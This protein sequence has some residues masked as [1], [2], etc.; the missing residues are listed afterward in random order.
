M[1]KVIDNRLLIGK[2]QIRLLMTIL[3]VI[4]RAPKTAYNHPR[5]RIQEHPIMRL[6]PSES[7]IQIIIPR[8][9]SILHSISA[10]VDRLEVEGVRL[11][12]G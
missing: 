10:S 1:Q 5:A 11:D 9:H 12:R 7:R 3:K 4:S 2:Q 6:L 8:H